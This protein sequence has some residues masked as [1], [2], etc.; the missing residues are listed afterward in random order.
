MFWDGRVSEG[1]GPQRFQAPAGIVLP[2]GTYEPAR[3][4]GDASRHESRRDAR[5]SRAIAM[6]S[7]TSNELAQIADTAQRRD[8]GRDDEARAGRLRRICRSSPPR[9]P[10]VS[11]SQLGFQHAANAIATFEAQTFT[12]TNS[13]F[14]RYL[15]RD[16]NAMSVDA[17]RGALLFFGKARL[18][19]VS[20][21]SAAR[22]AVVRQRRRSATRPGRASRRRSTW[23]RRGRR[24]G[25][26]SAAISSSASRRSATWS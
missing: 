5:R 13:A 22:H 23:A 12:K 7:A 1:L 3:G 14:D 19:V 4:A 8:L 15:A 11:P 9:I 24:P 6:S 10:G 21:R 25:P 26:A 17:K 18:L 2:G 20:Q 16:D